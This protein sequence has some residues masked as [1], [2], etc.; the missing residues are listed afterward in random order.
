MENGD[1][2]LWITARQLHYGHLG[3]GAGFQE[4]PCLFSS[5]LDR[6]HRD[7]YSEGLVG[8]GTGFGN[9]RQQIFLAGK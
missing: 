7:I 1:K 8:E 2:R 6:E 5:H 3:L 4:F 9:P